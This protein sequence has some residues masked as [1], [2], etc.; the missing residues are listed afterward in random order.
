MLILDFNDSALR[1]FDDDQ[2]LASSPACAVLD[3]EHFLLGEKA[4]AK[5]R[6][7]PRAT[8]LKFWEQ[9]DQQPLNR[10]AGSARS[11]ADI[12][13]YHLRD[14]LEAVNTRERKVL[15]I[16]PA[17][18][19]SERLALL[20]GIVQACSLSVTGIVESAVLAAASTPTAADREET[21][22]YLDISLHRVIVTDINR[23][24]HWQTGT[25]RELWTPGLSWCI[26]QCIHQ[27]SQR[28]LQETR[29]D[30]LHEAASEQRLFDQLPGWWQTFREHPKLTVELPAG[31]R[32]HRIEWRREQAELAL[33]SCYQ[34]LQKVVQ[35]ASGRVLI[36]HRLA[37]LPGLVETLQPCG[38]TLVLS[39]TALIDCAR[40]QQ[41]RLCSDAE[42]PLWVKQLPL[43]SASVE[44]C[45][46]DA[47]ANRS[48]KAQLQATHFLHNSCAT[49]LA[50]D[51]R[52]PADK[53]L[54][55]FNYVEGEYQVEALAA[56]IQLNGQSLAGVATLA[57]GDTLRTPQGEVQMI[58]VESGH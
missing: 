32:Q 46:T 21:L 48:D 34:E 4:L 37:A 20:L 25:A 6:L 12:A 23:N 7:N 8:Y 29:F 15:L 51:L 41:E 30:P 38:N 40:E 42:A 50:S 49:P 57:L 43:S 47:D 54:L 35:E 27:I 28:F 44:P 9:L 11:H 1:L 39:D 33:D 3:G 31:L 24:G 18:Y 17:H 56:A 19:G 13:Y 36:S 2:L 58:R 16:V 14:L 55:H 52:W 45:D 10:P 53:P 22:R 26:E 5:S